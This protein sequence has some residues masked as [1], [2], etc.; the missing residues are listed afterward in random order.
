MQK[1]PPRLAMI[2]LSYRISDSLLLVDRLDA[3]LTRSFSRDAV[4]RDKTRLRGGQNWTREL[5]DNA[6]TRRVMLVVIGGTW[7]TAAYTEAD[8]LGMLR[9]SDA[10]DWVRKEITFSLAA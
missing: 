4:F 9:L 6:R 8:R 5:E 7:Q 1:R 10:N 2:F 3:D